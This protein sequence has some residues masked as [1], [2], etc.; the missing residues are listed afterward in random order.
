M[1]RRTITSLA[2]PTV[3]AVRALHMRKA[4]QESGLFLVEGLKSVV[5]A[6]DL[7][8][9][10]RILLHAAA[11][12]SQPLL[13][14]VATVAAETLEV[15]ADILGKISRRDN[16]QTVLGVFEQ[17]FTPLPPSTRPRRAVG[18]CW[19]LCATRAI[20]ERS[21]APRTPPPAVG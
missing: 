3:K 2:N 4:R 20:S 12:A 11:A 21:S 16:P 8:K 18:W 10:P 9:S 15:S 19:R 6:V 13:E 1:S 17:A 14:R 5:E 7:G